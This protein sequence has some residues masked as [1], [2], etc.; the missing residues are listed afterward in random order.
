MAKDGISDHDEARM[1]ADDLL[2]FMAKEQK[3]SMAAEEC[4]KLIE[5]FEPTQDRKALS[6]EG[7]RHRL[8]NIP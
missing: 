5:A 2:A 4:E 1:T 6:M 8:F 7:K 3:V